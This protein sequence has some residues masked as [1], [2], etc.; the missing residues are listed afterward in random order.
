MRHR[1]VTVTV[2][3]DV[4]KAADALAKRLGRSRSWVVTEALRRYTAEPVAA[5]S[6][7]RVSEDW[8]APYAEALNAARSSLRDADLRLTP[9]ERLRAA[10]ELAEEAAR[11]GPPRKGP[12][13]QLLVFDR[14]E[15]WWAWKK[16]ESLP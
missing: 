1:R 7:Q 15:D 8:R 16:R 10:E 3:G 6:P 4:L 9:E 11:L 14:L 2:P 12:V 5:L 13:R